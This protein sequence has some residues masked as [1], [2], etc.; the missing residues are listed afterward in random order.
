MLHRSPAKPAK[1]HDWLPREAEGP[2]DQ[3]LDYTCMHTAVIPHEW[4]KGRDLIRVG[5]RPSLYVFR[6]E[7][8]FPGRSPRAV[9]TDAAPVLNLQL[10]RSILLRLTHEIGFCFRVAN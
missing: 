10:A 1:P 8:L 2:Q 5:R 3:S 4:L 6:F 7:Q 9:C